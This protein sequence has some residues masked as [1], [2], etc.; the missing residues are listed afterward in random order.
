[1]EKHSMGGWGRETKTKSNL[2][3][4]QRAFSTLLVDRVACIPGRDAAEQAA[5]LWGSEPFAVTE[6]LNSFC[7]FYS[8][9]WVTASPSILTTTEKQDGHKDPRLCRA[10]LLHSRHRPAAE[11]KQDRRWPPGLPWDT[12][13]TA[14][15]W[16]ARTDDHWWNVRT[17]F[18]ISEAAYPAEKSP[19][20]KVTFTLPSLLPLSL[21]QG[22]RYPA[23]PHKNPSASPPIMGPPGGRLRGDFMTPSSGHLCSRWSSEDDRCPGAIEVLVG[24]TRGLTWGRQCKPTCGA[25][26]SSR[27]RSSL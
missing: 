16:E 14:L 6:Q 15:W 3:N 2:P 7:I 1:M 13:S 10:S 12:A 22:P 8:D 20:E 9:S 21:S 26:Y 24:L 27:E 17:P 4:R 23:P 5:S 11:E 19:T 25:L 18:L